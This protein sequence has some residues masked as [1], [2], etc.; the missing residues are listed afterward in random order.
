MTIPLKYGTQIIGVL[1]IQSTIPAA[2]KNEDASLLS[3]LAN[4]IAIAINNV[5]IN[6]HAGFN[7]PS[8]KANRH[9]R[10][11]VRRQKQ[12]GYSY[13]V[14]GTI[15][16]A[17]PVTNQILEKALETGETVMQVQPSKNNPSTLAV[18][19]KFREQ[20]IGVIHIEAAETNRTWTEDEITVV[21]SISERAAFALENARLFEET[22]RHAEQEETIAHI[23][24]Q[25]GASTDFNRILKTTVE[26]LGRTLGAKRTF[27]QLETSSNDK[28]HPNRPVKD[29][30]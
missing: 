10:Q 5:L 20:V 9:G 22:S 27:I 2:F 18:P 21:Q 23:T 14:D 29:E 19:V 30:R 17:D 3:T 8:R 28:A 11:P 16:T 24:S 15:S 12:S 25:I 7:I 1:D 13:H 26:E 4:Q 6:E